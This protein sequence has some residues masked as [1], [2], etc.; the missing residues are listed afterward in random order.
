MKTSLIKLPDGSYINPAQISRIV[1]LDIIRRHTKGK[2]QNT[3]VTLMEEGMQTAVFISGIEDPLIIRE[4]H[5]DFALTVENTIN[6][7]N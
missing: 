5:D 4:S 3:I 6:S 2:A 1:P 7:V